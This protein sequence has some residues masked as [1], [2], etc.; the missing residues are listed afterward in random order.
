[1]LFERIVS[2]IS[3]LIVLSFAYSFLY[4]KK[5]KIAPRIYPLLI[6]FLFGGIS[7]IGMLVPLNFV[8]G[9]IFDGR[10]I[11]LSVGAFLGG[12]VVAVVAVIMAGIYRLFIGGSGALMGLGVIVTSALIGLL[13][14]HF[15]A[16]NQSCKIL[17]LYLFGMVVHVAMMLW[18]L[19]LP[20]NAR[21]DVFQKLTFPV[22][23]IYPLATVLLAKITMELEN[24][25]ETL[26]KLV[27]NEEKFRVLFE[28][29]A[30]GVVYQNADGVITS[31]NPAAERILG[32]TL[33]QLKGRTSIDP[34]WKAVDK[35]KNDMPGESHPAMVALRTGKEVQNFIQGIYNPE[36]NNYI[37][38]LVN[39]VPQFNHTEEKPSQV[40]S[41]F[42][43]ITE[44]IQAEDELRKLKNE[45]EKQV[46]E[47]TKELK[48]RIKE[49]ETFYEATV[50]REIRMGELREKINQIRNTNP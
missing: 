9:I 41:T 44:R 21:P 26:K 3:L 36:I 16:R 47:K 5:S 34:R 28:T 40:F 12:P 27:V 15:V 39:S 6:G 11:V 38:I 31:A 23:L 1:M 46:E 4:Q 19:A 50:E 37:W 45:L 29:K 22:L 30:E 2:N 18:M 10:S 35:D 25:F 42:T 17:Y 43:D 24:Y 48:N 20:G 49:L 33:D 13:Y 32:L 14:R 8:P 7:I